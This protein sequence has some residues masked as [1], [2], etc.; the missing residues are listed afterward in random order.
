MNGYVFCDPDAYGPILTRAVEWNEQHPYGAIFNPELETRP[1]DKQ[2]NLDKA[3]AERREYLRLSIAATSTPEFRA[4]LSK[5]AGN[6]ADARYCW[7]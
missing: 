7:R 3:L 4:E 5:R 1:G 2:A 6:G